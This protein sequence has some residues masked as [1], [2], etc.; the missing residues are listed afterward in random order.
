[1][2]KEKRKIKIF[3]GL[4]LFGIIKKSSDYFK[5]SFREFSFSIDSFRVIDGESGLWFK[6]GN[7]DSMTE[8]LVKLKNPETAPTMGQKAY[9][10][11]WVDPPT[12][13]KHIN[14]L[15]DVYQSILSRRSLAEVEKLAVKS[16]SHTQ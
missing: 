5:T 13:Q 12:I 11:F 2:E 16:E 7:L 10:N 14:R 6:G 9:D 3:Y 15:N 8:A 4:Y 1:M